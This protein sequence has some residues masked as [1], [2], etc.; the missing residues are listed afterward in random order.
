MSRLLVIWCFMFGASAGALDIDHAAIGGWVDRDYRERLSWNKGKLTWNAEDLKA[1][2]ILGQ[3]LAARL[4]HQSPL[5]SDEGVQSYVS[6]VGHSILSQV[7]TEGRPFRFAVINSAQRQ[8]YALPGGYIFVTRGMLATIRTEAE[9][10]GVLANGIAQV[11]ARYGVKLLGLRG[12]KTNVFLDYVS[13]VA[14]K[15]ELGDKDQ[16]IHHFRPWLWMLDQALQLKGYH[17]LVN[18]ARLPLLGDGETTDDLWQYPDQFSQVILGRLQYDWHAHA[19]FLQRQITEP[20]GRIYWRQHHHTHGDP[21]KRLAALQSFQ[22]KFITGQQGIDVSVKPWKQQGRTRYQTAV[23]PVL[24]RQIRQNKMVQDL[25]IRPLLADSTSQRLIQVLV[26]S[27]QQLMNVPY[28]QQ[29]RVMVVHDEQPIWVQRSDYWMVSDGFL[30]QVPSIEFFALIVMVQQLNGDETAHESV[31]PLLMEL[32]LSAHG[33]IV[34]WN[35]WIDWLESAAKSDSTGKHNQAQWLGLDGYTAAR[36]SSVPVPPVN[37][38][39][40]SDEV[41]SLP[42]LQPQLQWHLYRQLS[43]AKALQYQRSLWL[44]QGQYLHRVIRQKPLPARVVE[45]T[46]SFDGQGL[47]WPTLVEVWQNMQQRLALPSAQQLAQT[48]LGSL[49]WYQQEGMN[50][51]VRVLVS[52]ASEAL[53]VPAPLFVKL[54]DMPK[55]SHRHQNGWL[56]ISTGAIEFA[57]SEGELMGFIVNALL[58]GSDSEAVLIDRYK[59]L[60]GTKLGSVGD[61]AQQTETDEWTLWRWKDRLIF[62]TLSELGYAPNLWGHWL[63][64]ADQYPRLNLSV[65]QVKWRLR[66]AE[67][68][69][70]W[71]SQH[72]DFFL[73]HYGASYTDRLHKAKQNWL[74]PALP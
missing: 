39:E 11:L 73:S 24:L 20:D 69:L 3:L 53:G 33:A 38:K 54:E 58:D 10:V 55:V 56:V 29:T 57:Q 60:I 30:R 34:L 50:R 31:I 72:Q 18:Q 62:Q 9:L 28:H 15:V 36:S 1:E 19:Q 67:Q 21:G 23:E 44:A 48:Q 71:L 52:M 68:S 22:S 13:R 51:Y 47:A 43:E 37:D 2:I 7:H 40:E 63:A 26:A 27:L 8:I 49:P 6:M 4:L 16:F 64:Q 46:E 32:G 70:H 25:A 61:I 12:V 42:L 14:D 65:Q 5:L 45:H 17:N 41:A 74:L 66:Q 35:R 59:Q